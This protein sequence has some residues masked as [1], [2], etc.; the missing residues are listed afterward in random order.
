MAPGALGSLPLRWVWY[1]AAALPRVALVAR[2]EAVARSVGGFAPGA[3]VPGPHK[4]AFL[5]AARWAAW[6]VTLGVGGAAGVLVAPFPPRLAQALRGVVAGTEVG[7]G[8]AGAARGAGGA[9]PAAPAVAVAL[10]AVTAAGEGSGGGGGAA[11]P[12]RPWSEPIPAQALLLQAAW[13]HA[14]LALVP[15]PLYL[16]LRALEACNL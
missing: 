2:G 3:F 8:A 13:A 7:G 10:T 5:R 15:P 4:E 12:L 6:A 1:G 11:Q 14:E 16:A 9:L